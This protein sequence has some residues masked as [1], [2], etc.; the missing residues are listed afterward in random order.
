MPPGFIRADAPAAGLRFYFIA[1]R[2]QRVCL[3][4]IWLFKANRL[5]VLPSLSLAGARA[6]DA[7]RLPRDVLAAA[8]Y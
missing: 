5:A 1:K 2:L 4:M 7:R 8:E 6:A 3:C